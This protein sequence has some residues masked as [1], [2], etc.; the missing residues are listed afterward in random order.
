VYAYDVF[1]EEK[2]INFNEK[3]LNFKI[4]NLS[5]KNYSSLQKYTTHSKSHN[6]TSHSKNHNKFLIGCEQKTRKQCGRKHLER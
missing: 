4:E 2:R 3:F 5:V 1:F 6:P